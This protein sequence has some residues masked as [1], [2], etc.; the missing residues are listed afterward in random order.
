MKLGWDKALAIDNYT[1]NQI[2]DQIKT[3]NVLLSHLDPKRTKRAY[4]FPCNNDIIEG[5]DYSQIL[6]E[7]HLVTYARTGG[8]ST[9]IV[10][11]FEHLNTMKV[12]SWLVFTGTRAGQ[13]IAFAEKV[14]KSNG[15]GI[16]QFHGIGGQ[17]FQVSADAHKE[18]ITYLTAHKNDFQILTFSDALEQIS[19]KNK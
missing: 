18:F 12:P 6:K 1:L 19:G 3:Q 15:L 4:A 8:D 5:K 9:S 16:Y 7:Q 13:L 11:D 2:I 14:K 10:T 17:I